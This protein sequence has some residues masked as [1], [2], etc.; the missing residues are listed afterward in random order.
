MENTIYIYGTIFNSVKTIDM[1]IDSLKPLGSYK[2][3]VVDNFS[4]DGTYEKLRKYENCIVV[5][6]HCSR[7]EGREIA[8]NILLRDSKP[9]SP[10]MYIDLD[11][12]LTKKAIAYIKKR[13]ECLEDNVFYAIGCLGTAETHAK[14]KWH[15]LMLGDDTEF[16]AQ[17]ISKSIKVYYF[18]RDEILKIIKDISGL[19][20]NTSTADREKRYTKSRIGYYLRLFRLLVDA[21]R[22][23]AF[24]SPREFFNNSLKAQNA[25]SIKVK[26]I[27][28]LSFVFSIYALAFF[29]AHIKGVYEYSKYKN[30]S[31]YIRGSGKFIHEDL[32][33]LVY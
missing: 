18:N 8:K 16:V 25:K 30:N 4:T 24:K 15:D 14:V 13:M 7:G 11:I 12:K 5:R 29:I 28:I 33:S 22:G 17:A 10:V 2:L 19:K 26:N 9:N 21:E 32:S 31:Q 1:C 27:L 20:M 23:N 6:R 3:Y